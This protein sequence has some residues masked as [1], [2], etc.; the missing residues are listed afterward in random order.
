[1]QYDPLPLDG[2]FPWPAGIRAGDSIAFGRFV[3]NL[4]TRT[5]QE[6]PVGPVSHLTAFD[7]PMAVHDV[8]TTDIE[9]DLIL[10]QQCNKRL[11]RVADRFE[12]RVALI[13]PGGGGRFEHEYAIH[14]LPGRQD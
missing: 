11:K 9:F 2:L 3:L 10:G 6:F 13:H 12:M 4:D 7:G 8:F 1:M 14:L 5:R